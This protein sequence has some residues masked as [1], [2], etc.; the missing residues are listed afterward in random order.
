MLEMPS[1]VSQSSVSGTGASFGSSVRPCGQIG[2]SVQAC[3]SVTLPI[4]PAQIISA[5]WRVPSCREPCFPLCLPTLFF[6]AAPPHSPPSPPP[7]PTPF[8]TQTFF[9]P[10][11]PP[12]PPLP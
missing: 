6:F 2:R 11:L 10:P 8:F 1:Q 12:I 4:S 7:P 9:P 5:H 3:T